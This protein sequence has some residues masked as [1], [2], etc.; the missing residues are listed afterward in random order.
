MSEWKS[1]SDAHPLKR[2]IAF[3]KS[4]W[5]YIARI[6]THH[7]DDPKEQSRIRIYNQMNLIVSLT[8]IPII[9]IDLSRSFIPGLLIAMG[10]FLTTAGSFYF[11]HIGKFRMVIWVSIIL[12]TAAVLFLVAYFG[13]SFGGEL[14]FLTIGLSSIILFE[15]W[16]SRIIL[17]IYVFAIF[18]LSEFSMMYLDPVADQEE[19]YP[20]YWIVFFCSLFVTTSLVGYFIREG[21][22]SEQRTK[23]L[24][25]N[26]Q[27]QNDAL[28]KA[29]HDLSQFAYASSHHF[30][31]PLKNISNLLGL[32]E[33]KLPEG[34]NQSFMN[35][36][37]SVKSDAR[38]LYSLVEDILTYSTLESADPTVLGNIE[39]ESVI[40]R[41]IQNLEEEL[42]RCNGSVIIE[43]LPVLQAKESHIELMMQILIQNGI[44]YNTSA[45]PEIHISAKQ[46]TEGEVKIFVADNGIGIEE[47]YHEQIFDPFLRLHSQEQI[48]GTGIGLTVCKQIMKSYEGDITLTSIP[49]KGSVFQLV[50]PSIPAS[51]SAPLSNVS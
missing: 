48:E 17:L 25:Q 46:S 38:H 49:G 44:K 10:I 41:V 21:D 24:M 42:N 40:K 20:I 19:L 27:I 6:G 2:G 22:Q 33:R 32:I 14:I 1:E 23:V 47:A 29:N 50:F 9:L 13:R 30:K 35:H 28:L 12:V 31:S 18:L 8:M 37:E 15:E 16:K 7:E 11:I 45:L 3:C 26:L 51:P 4:V 43:P 36:L 39:I 5:Q 34:V